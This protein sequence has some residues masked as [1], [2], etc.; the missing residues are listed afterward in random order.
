MSKGTHVEVRARVRAKNN[1]PWLR[2]LLRVLE[3]ATGVYALYLILFNGA[4]AT[5]VLQ[6]I[7]NRDPETASFRW[8]SAYSVWPGTVH[9]RGFVFRGQ[10]SA[11]QWRMSFD[12]ARASFA[13]TDLFSKRVHITH[14]WARGVS[15]R[16]RQKL[17][18]NDIGSD[19]TRMLPPIDGFSDPPIR[20]AHPPDP[21]D[22]DYPFFTIEL[23]D[24]WGERVREVW[25]DE[26]RVA[27]DGFV[28]G[29]FTLKPLR[30]IET[31]SDAWLER[32]TVARGEDTIVREARGKAHFEM[33]AF[34]PRSD[35]LVRTLSGHARMQGEIP[36]LAP[37][38]RKDVAL[39]GGGGPF[40]IDFALE[41]GVVLE[42][43]AHAHARAWQAHRWPHSLAGSSFL[44]AHV[45]KD[46]FLSA[47]NEHVV[48]RR[49]SAVTATA[50]SIVLFAR[51]SANLAD[52]ERPSLSVEVSDLDVPRLVVLDS[53]FGSPVFAKGSANASLHLDIQGNNARGR[54]NVR[55]DKAEIQKTTLD[56]K[57]AI[58]ADSIDLDRKRATLSGTRL[59][60]RDPVTGWW[61][62]A[63]I[64]RGEIA[65][66]DI[67]LFVIGRARDASIPLRVLDVGAIARSILA[68]DT[69]SILGHLHAGPKLLSIDG[70]RVTGSGGLEVVAKYTERGEAKSGA[71][72]VRKG[73]LMTGVV[74]RGSD[75]SLRPFADESWYRDTPPHSR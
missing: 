37:L 68:S 15:I 39:S 62:N 6:K 72:L 44:H 47:T 27:G 63:E 30:K 65:D 28:R 61:A 4:I 57:L 50:A 42:G 21:G 64:A 59:D 54:A 74:V 16:I 20:T 19:K 8:V 56:G 33:L 49:G 12:E 55:F 75:V 45:D 24:T 14:G 35:E 36:S 18:P 73:P 66:R 38:P 69:L 23:E 67:D 32:C 31:K 2:I 34:D 43:R 11:L 29:G 10:D 22:A 60:V 13:I 53:Y 70:V 52:L 1:G 17:E 9:A 7:L 25:V 46:V 71:A 48:L 58:T 3:I 51:T 26:T 41:R 40:A 5:G